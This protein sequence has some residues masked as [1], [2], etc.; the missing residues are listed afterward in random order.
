MT[1]DEHADVIVTA[2]QVSHFKNCPDEVGDI[3]RHVREAARTQVLAAVAE[4]LSHRGYVV[5]PDGITLLHCENCRITAE[6]VAE[7]RET[8]AKVAE[9]TE[10]VLDDHPRFRF[11][12][13]GTQVASAIRARAHAD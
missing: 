8:C 13:K 5:S 9:D 1:P 12:V 3:S 2:M 6:A 4:A 11:S 10:I 7:E